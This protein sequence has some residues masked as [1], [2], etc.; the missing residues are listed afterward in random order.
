MFIIFMIGLIENKSVMTIFS[1]IMSKAKYKNLSSVSFDFITES[2]NF[3]IIH[4]KL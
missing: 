3:K 2:F 4:I 1:I